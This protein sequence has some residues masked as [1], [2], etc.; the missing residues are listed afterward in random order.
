VVQKSVE[1]RGCDDLVI[2]NGPP[3]TDTAVAGYQVA[4]ALVAPTD[5]GK[6]QMS[7]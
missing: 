6:E 3:L 2:Q 5:Q 7:G 1:D 4:A